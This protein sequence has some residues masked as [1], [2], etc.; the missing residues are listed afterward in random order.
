[1]LG[2]GGSLEPPALALITIE[3]NGI[4][5]K[6]KLSEYALQYHRLTKIGLFESGMVG[7]EEGPQMS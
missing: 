3:F 5:L 6:R 7:K 2:V 1:M 4:D